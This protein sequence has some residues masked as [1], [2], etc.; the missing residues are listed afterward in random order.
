MS[1]ARNLTRILDSVGKLLSGKLPDDALKDADIG[2]A[3]PAVLPG[4]VVQSVF[5]A[6]ATHQTVT[7]QIPSDD[8]VPQITEGTQLISAS[9]TPTSASNKIRCTFKAGLVNSVKG[10]N[11][12]AALFK[13]AG[14]NAIAARTNSSP[15]ANYHMPVSCEAEF[16]A[17]TTSPILVSVRIGPSATATVAINGSTT[18]RQLGGASKV[19][20]VLEEIKI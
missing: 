20:L 3:I 18:G 9:I 14:P 13:D 1:N 2:T 8:T 12:V 11:I 16:V 19:T 6:D 10:T 7:A 15:D 17:G 4:T 5:M